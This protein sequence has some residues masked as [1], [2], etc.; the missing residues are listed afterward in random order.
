MPFSAVWVRRQGTSSATRILIGDHSTSGSGPYL[1]DD[2]RSDVLLK[3]PNTLGRVFDTADLT[4]SLVRRTSSSLSHSHAASWKQRSASQS[5]KEE[6]LSPDEVIAE[7]LRQEYS[8]GQT[9]NEALVIST[10]NSMFS[11]FHF[12]PFLSLTCS[13]STNVAADG[14]TCSE[15]AEYSIA[16][17]YSA[18]AY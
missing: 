14:D 4:V 17:A 13:C 10:P 2:L 16:A 1:V 5:R 7:V 12:I 11:L 3:F 15:Y 18:C 6:E 9:Y 8:G